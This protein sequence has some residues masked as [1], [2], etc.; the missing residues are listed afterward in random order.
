MIGLAHELDLGLIQK[1]SDIDYNWTDK[2][3]GISLSTIKIFILERICRI[4]V[5]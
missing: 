1:A 4:F 2:L 5:E 3:Q